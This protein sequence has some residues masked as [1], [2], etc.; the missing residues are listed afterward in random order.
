MSIILGVN[1][2]GE[3]LNSAQISTGSEIN[4]RSPSVTIAGTMFV[5]A[6][7]RTLVTT[8][9]N[10]SPRTANVDLLL[11]LLVRQPAV[12]GGFLALRGN[13]RARWLLQAWSG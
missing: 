12:A 10:S 5:A 1:Q 2:D 7:S 8:L 13:D 6:G 11:P 4:K 9:L 3:E